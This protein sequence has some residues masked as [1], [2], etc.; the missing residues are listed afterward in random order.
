MRIAVDVM[1]GDNPPQSLCTA[2]VDAAIRFGPQ[3]SLTLVATE[4]VLQEFNRRWQ[5]QYQPKIHSR[6]E[7]CLAADFISMGDDPVQA[8]R[9]RKGS[10]LAMGIRLIKKHQADAF[11]TA[12]NTGAL[13]ASAT[14]SLPSLPGITRPALLATLPTENG[15]VVVIDVGGNVYCKAR[16]LVKFAQMGAAYQRCIQNIE[17]PRVGLLNIGVESKKGSNELRQA[18]QTLKEEGQN[19]VAQGLSPGMTFLGNVEGRDIFK[20]NVDVIVTDGFTGNI[21]LKSA[22][23]TAS[24]IFKYL[25]ENCPP[26]NQERLHQ[27]LGQLNRHFNYA[28]YPGA[29]VCGVEGIVVKCHGDSTAKALLNSIE[30]AFNLVQ[31]RLVHRI[32]EQLS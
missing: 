4:D 11:V 31:K 23:G 8:A 12:G 9:H 25:K 24:F 10:S 5:E 21:L 19:L 32:K 16:H 27:A 2:I 28:E 26:Q 13:I 29:I 20:G 14:L 3:H 22:E 7:Y 6:V 30:G 1:G 15:F 18:Y 17:L